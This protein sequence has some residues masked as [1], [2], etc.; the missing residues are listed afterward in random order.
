MEALTE[1]E[2]LDALRAAMAVPEVD[3]R[4]LTMGELSE[5]L[6]LGVHVLTLRMRVLIKSGQAVC[7]RKPMMDITGRT[8]PVPAYRLAA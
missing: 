5:Q 2:V 1:N 3:E 4:A 6:G 7:V 8:R